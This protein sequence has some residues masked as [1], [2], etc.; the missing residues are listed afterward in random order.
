MYSTDPA[1]H[2]VRAGK[3]VGDLSVRSS[4]GSGRVNVPNWA[5]LT[6]HKR[7]RVVSLTFIF[8]NPPGEKKKKKKKKLSVRNLSDACNLRTFG[9]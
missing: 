3:N 1:E 7:G 8:T 5:K 9:V 2:L 6:R 4:R